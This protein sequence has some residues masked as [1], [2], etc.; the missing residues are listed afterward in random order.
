[1]EFKYPKDNN[2]YISCV[3]IN[4]IGQSEFKILIQLEETNYKILN[5][6]EII[7]PWLEIYNSQYILKWYHDYIIEDNT[8]IISSTN[9]LNGIWNNVMIK[10]SNIYKIDKNDISKYYR[11]KLSNILI[12]DEIYQSSWT[13]IFSLRLNQFIENRFDISCCIFWYNQNT[14]YLFL[15]I[16]DENYYEKLE[17]SC[18]IN[19]Q[20]LASI[21]VYKSLD[22]EYYL[23]N[24]S[25]KC[26]SI[27]INILERNHT[28]L[29]K[30]PILLKINDTLLEVKKLAYR[31]YDIQITV[32]GY[33]IEQFQI[34]NHFQVHIYDIFKNGSS[35]LSKTLLIGGL[36][37]LKLNTKKAQ[38]RFC[39][40]NLSKTSEDYSI[41]FH[42]IFHDNRKIFILNKRFNLISLKQTDTK[43][44]PKTLKVNQTKPQHLYIIPIVLGIVFILILLIIYSYKTSKRFQKFISKRFYKNFEIYYKFEKQNYYN[45]LNR[46]TKFDFSQNMPTTQNHNHYLDQETF[47]S[48]PITELQFKMINDLTNTDKDLEECDKVFKEAVKLTISCNGFSNDIIN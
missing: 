13:N 20:L 1:M 38:I 44:S 16:F 36:P 43:A 23:Y 47:T 15:K 18:Y 33:Q 35:E 30:S 9:D 21:M 6:F 7:G 3:A 22:N 31:S 4:D 5:G 41:S 32:N 45:L 8:F 26:Q 48:S 14:A 25:A 2:I 11:I 19:N 29:E 27:S 28:I 24:I 37:P 42:G 12:E 46:I 39:I 34:F 10:H 40:F 17:I